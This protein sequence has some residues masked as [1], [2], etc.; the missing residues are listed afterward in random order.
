MFGLELF[1]VQYHGGTV[2]GLLFRGVVFEAIFGTLKSGPWRRG[3]S[4]PVAHF[5]RKLV[6]LFNRKVWRIV[7]VRHSDRGF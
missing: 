1:F 5:C 6:S 2:I 3:P 7:A 4:A